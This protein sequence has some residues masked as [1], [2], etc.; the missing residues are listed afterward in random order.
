MMPKKSAV[1]TALA[2]TLAAVPAAARAQGVPSDAVLRGFQPTGDYTL[3]VNA[4]P[5]PAA[6][7]YLNEKLPAMLVLTSALSS[8]I[9]LTPRTGSVETVN[10]MKVSKQT[11]G[12]VD[13]LA[14]AVLAPAGQFTTQG[15]NVLFTFESKKVSLNPKPPLLGVKTN[16]QLK[17]HS[18][19]YARGAKLYKP[20]GAAIADLKKKTI[21]VTVRVFFGS[22]CPHCRQH[23]PYILKVEDELQNPKIKFEYLGL[24]R[25]FNN[26]EAKRLKIN[27]VPTGVI[28]VNGKEVGRIAGTGWDAP[29]VL[30]NRIVPA[31]KTNAPAPPARPSS[32]KGKGGPKR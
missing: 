25:D 18:P 1:L 23:V 13:L 4:K 32:T 29:E 30:L 27:S 9:L 8:P 26:P 22:W 16:A 21:P 6:E 19:D 10:I 7:I 5:V 24:P 3:F 14:D 2:L 28:Y 11:D 31:A 17:A 20:N 15:E 12:S